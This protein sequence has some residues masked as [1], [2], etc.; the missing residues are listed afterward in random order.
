VP[1]LAPAEAARLLREAADLAQG[2]RAVSRLIEAAQGNA[3]HLLQGAAQLRA[4]PE[5]VLPPDLADL[6]AARVATLPPPLAA[7]LRAAAVLGDDLDA[8]SLERT[9][10]G[11]V[12][13]TVLLDALVSR[14]FLTRQPEGHR[15]VHPHLGQLVGDGIPAPER[16][17]LHLRVADD[18]AG[19]EGSASRLSYHLWHSSKPERAIEPLLAAGERCLLALSDAAAQSAFQRALSLLPGPG[20]P[21]VTLEQRGQWLRAVRGLVLA[22]AAGGEPESAGTVQSSTASLAEAAGWHVEAA[23]LETLEIG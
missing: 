12:P 22:L 4:R 3:L 19:R 15:F 16:A 21:E 18:L 23:L 11:A 17:G 6:V 13:A 7:A 9:V 20:G 10:S 5:G 8:A 14:S 1:P 2:T